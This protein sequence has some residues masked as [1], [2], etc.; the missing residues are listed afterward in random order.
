MGGKKFGSIRKKHCLRRNLLR[1][2]LIESLW[3]TKSY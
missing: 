1:M 3:A 2:Q